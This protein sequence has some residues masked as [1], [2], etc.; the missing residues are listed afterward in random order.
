MEL[1]KLC[2]ITQEIY[3]VSNFCQIGQ[4]VWIPL[5]LL[6]LHIPYS[7]SLTLKWL[8]YFPTVGAQRGGVF[9]WTQPQKTTFPVEFSDKNYTIYRVRQIMIIC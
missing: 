5:G 2:F 1:F 7:V 6:H 3:L 9:L 8:R 4:I